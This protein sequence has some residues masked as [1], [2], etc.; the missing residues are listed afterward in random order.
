[1]A[2]A[3]SKQQQRQAAAARRR[4]QKKLFAAGGIIGVL[5]LGLLF[6]RYWPSAET[7]SIEGHYTKGPENAP[8]VMKEF[9]D[10]R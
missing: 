6:V 3:R 10:Y 4:Q 2:M 9:S 5:I 8:I 7:G 1:M